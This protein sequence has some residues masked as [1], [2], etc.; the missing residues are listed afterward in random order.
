MSNQASPDSLPSGTELDGSPKSAQDDV[1]RR[2]SPG[3]QIATSI[4]LGLGAA[5]ALAIAKIN[6]TEL[7]AGVGVVTAS[8]GYIL[9]QLKGML[10]S[11]QDS[12]RAAYQRKSIGM[13]KIRAWL[14][15]LV[16]L[17]RS[18]DPDRFW[19]QYDNRAT[20]WRDKAEGFAA[21]STSFRDLKLN[22][23]LCDLAA[24]LADVDSF[25]LGEDDKPVFKR[26]LQT[27]A[28]DAIAALE[29]AQSKAR[30]VLSLPGASENP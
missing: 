7:I 14:E 11:Y 4:V 23:A 5:A 30:P 27:L 24:H 13:A 9:T 25:E 12:K 28:N 6:S 17:T 3:R 18:P 19:R 15:N 8:G 16:A 21:T 29:T 10:T 2:S 20:V 26:R 1:E 22:I